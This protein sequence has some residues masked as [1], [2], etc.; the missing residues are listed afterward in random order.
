MESEQMHRAA[1][2]LQTQ[3]FKGGKV[4]DYSTQAGS[5][6]GHGSERRAEE[7]V[8][9][10]VVMLRTIQNYIWKPTIIDAS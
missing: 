10:W 2:L 1:R 7:G 5:H 4:Q 9:R 6:Q 8:Q 3:G